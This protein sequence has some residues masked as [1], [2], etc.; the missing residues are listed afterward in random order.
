MMKRIAILGC[1]S[2]A[3][4][5][6]QTT[7]PPGTTVVVTG[8]YVTLDGV[9]MTLDQYNFLLLNG[10]LSGGVHQDVDIKLA[11]DADSD[12]SPDL[13]SRNRYAI[14]AGASAWGGGPWSCSGHQAFSSNGQTLSYVETWSYAVT[15]KLGVEVEIATASL[16]TMVT[17]GGQLT[18]VA[19]GNNGQW[20]CW[21]RRDI[22][23][24]NNYEMWEEWTDILGRYHK[25]DLGG[26]YLQYVTGVE[27]LNKITDGYTNCTM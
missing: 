11:T 4:L 25:K 24:N 12:A 21:W 19:I 2:L 5:M 3:P 27:A 8:N 14:F 18:D 9:T 20:V 13:T 1:L 26:G 10:A 6:S 16:E 22:V 17:K 7:T 23:S 15:A